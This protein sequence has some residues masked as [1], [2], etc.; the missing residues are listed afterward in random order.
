MMAY[1]DICLM[2]ELWNKKAKLCG[3]EKLCKVIKQFIVAFEHI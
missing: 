1:Y 3:K 2:E